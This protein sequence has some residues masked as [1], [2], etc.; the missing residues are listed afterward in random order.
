[1]KSPHLPVIAGALAIAFSSLAATRAGAQTS[2]LLPGN[3]VVVVYGNTPTANG[4]FLDGNATPIT[5]EQFPLTVA[6]GVDN[7]TPLLTETLPTTGTGANVGIVGEYGSSS[8]GTILVSGDGRFVSFGGYDGNLAE[9]GAPAGGYGGG[10]TAEAQSTCAH[11]PR[12]AALV[13]I[14]TGDVDTSTVLNDIYNT[15]NPRGVYTPT[16]RAS[17]S[18]ARAPTPPTRAVST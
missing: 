8:E 14:A 9:N 3:L 17:I 6:A 13:N 1:M 10:N 7:A 12:V 2:P 18:P 5:L 4:T 11:V 15:N 16:D